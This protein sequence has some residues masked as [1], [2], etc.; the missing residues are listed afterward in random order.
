MMIRNI[1]SSEIETAD[2]S[3]IICALGFESRSIAVASKLQSRC[4]NKLA[5]GFDHNHEYSYNENKIWFIQHS[6]SVV[7]DLNSSNFS[8]ALV[9]HA[10]IHL[11]NSTDDNASATPSIAIDISCFDRRRLADLVQWLRSKTTLD[12]NIDFWY[13]IGNFHPPSR[14][15]GRNEIAGPVHRRFAGRFVEPGRPLALVA[16]LGYELG[17]VVGAAEYLQTSRIV[18]FIPESPILEYESEVYAANSTMLQDLQPRQVL[19]YPVADPERTLAMLD[20]TI[21]GLEENYNVVLLPGG[22][23]VFAFCSLI[24]CTMH[25][26]AAVWRV[27]SGGSIRARDILPSSHFVGSRCEANSTKDSEVWESSNG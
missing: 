17:R 26:N 3:L 23:K 24:A 2:Y 16:G 12:F 6:F 8:A 20:S 14:T 25:P 7:S 11:T 9:S 22:P 10:D 15:A 4:K 18:A 19:R 21:R 27:S 5:L 1:P 13:C